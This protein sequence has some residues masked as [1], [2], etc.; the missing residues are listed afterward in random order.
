MIRLSATIKQIIFLPLLLLYGITCSA[1]QAKKHI[2]ILAVYENGGHHVAYS[3]AAKTWLD[4]LAADSNYTV[5]YLNS[6]KTFTNKLLKKYNLI[7]QLDYPPYGWGKTAE[8]AFRKYITEGRGGWIG[9][10][11]ASLTGDFD[12]FKMWNWYYDFIGGIKFKNYIATFADATVNVEQRKHPVFKGVP[13]E[14]IIE[15][16]E[17]YTYDKSPRANVSVL[18]GVDEKS[19]KPASNVVMGDHPV[20]WTN[21]KF[22][23]RNIYIF[24]G[25]SPKLFS[26][27][28]YTTLFSN[29]IVWASSKSV[30]D[31]N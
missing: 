1:Q 30:A 27:M 24:M 16:D 19:Y 5:D 18:A 23:A 8:Q 31:E 4:K 11:H 15:G 6:P 29:A 26:N 21:P 13:N 22:K 25:H 28:A 7:I 14:F 10:H 17:W 9:F 2:S 3:T 12:G 20:I